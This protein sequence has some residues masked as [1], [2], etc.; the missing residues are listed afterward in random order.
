VANLSPNFPLVSIQAAFSTGAIGQDSASLTTPTSPGWTMN[1]AVYSI[2]DA[3]TVLGPTAAGSTVTLPSSWAIGNVYPAWSSLATYAVGGM[4][5]HAGQ[6]WYAVADS[7]NVIPSA[8]V[9]EWVL[10]SPDW[11]DITQVVTGMDFS[12]GSQYEVSGPETGSA[13]LTCVDVPENL[14]PGNP[15]SPYN[16]G[17]NKLVPYRP[18][19]IHAMWPNP[20]APAVGDPD[21]AGPYNIVNDVNALHPVTP[22]STSASNF[23]GLTPPL[24]EWAAQNAASP[25]VELSQSTTHVRTG[26]FS[27]QILAQVGAPGT[28]TL[29]IPTVP[30]DTFT[31]SVYV[32]NPSVGGATSVGLEV[33]SGNGTSLGS[34]STAVKNAFTRVT[35]TF[36]AVSWAS[37]LRIE[38]VFTTAGAAVWADD[39][40]VEWGALAGA[41]TDTDGQGMYPQF[42]GYA[43]RYPT[44][45][46]SSGFQG[47]TDMECVDAIS[48]SS[49]TFLFDALQNQIMAELMDYYP[50]PAGGNLKMPSFYW[51]LDDGVTPQQQFYLQSQVQPVAQSAYA[52]TRT[53]DS[54]Q[55]PLYQRTL[56]VP[57]PGIPPAGAWIGT[58]AASQ[59]IDSVSSGN[60]NSGAGA[61]GVGYYMHTDIAADTWNIDISGTPTV[62]TPAVGCVVAA[63]NSVPGQNGIIWHAADVARGAYV[64]LRINNKKI[65]MDWDDGAGQVGTGAFAT[66]P[67]IGSDMTDGY[68]RLWQVEMPTGTG[69][70]RL[71]QN[72]IELPLTPAPTPATFAG[73]SPT[74]LDIGQSPQATGGRAEPQFTGQISNL[75]IGPAIDSRQVFLAMADLAEESTPDRIARLANYGFQFG[76]SIAIKPPAAGVESVDVG[77]LQGLDKKT[78]TAALTEVADTNIGT[79]FAD[80]SGGIEIVSLWNL[81]VKPLVATFGED[82]VAGEIPY[83]GDIKY[84]MDPQFIYNMVTATQRASL[85]RTTN[86]LIWQPTVNPP[87]TGGE[88]AK[89]TG[90]NL[91]SL[92]A[93]MEND[94]VTEIIPKD[95]SF[96]NVWVTQKLLQFSDAL[97][98]IDS[99]QVEALSHPAALPT[100]LGTPLYSKVQ[101]TRRM[102][103][104]VT[105]STP[106]LITKASVRVEWGA[107]GGQWLVDYQLADFSKLQPA[108]GDV[109]WYMEDPVASIMGVTTVLCEDPPPPTSWLIGVIGSSETGTTTFFG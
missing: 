36:E 108:P 38:S 55:L 90:T 4:V 33:V 9:S 88:G 77:T 61:S 66:P 1:D 2:M 6:V 74:V 47:W 44:R 45:W 100:V 23:E 14:Q 5:T 34:A 24:G 78:L 42:F 32:Y 40:Q 94:L 50:N 48:M 51:P 15:S 41:Y 54:G 69:V 107:S 83:L 72:G 70:P 35:V 96:C 64:Q 58:D 95:A 87:N 3:T 59:L 27:M 60:F 53:A 63:P 43:E 104:N 18:M 46:E 93:Y 86:A 98:R 52:P 71:L 12:Q 105:M 76:R 25:D 11:A 31:A 56:G 19:A 22:L 97:N 7:L 13:K 21:Y 102:G 85:N 75:Y 67:G 57:P 49:R 29:L 101:V 39:V 28:A 92:N 91:A 106:N 16:S 37:Q 103:N 73:F 62:I 84:S 10:V 65:T 26:T 79:L 109:C 89:V 30:G 81:I 68:S 8:N 80:R 17:N 20:A 99:M 82:T